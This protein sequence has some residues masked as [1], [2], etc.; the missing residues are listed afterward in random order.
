MLGNGLGAFTPAA[1]S[2]ITVSGGPFST[3]TAD[4][5]N[6]GKLD[7]ATGNFAGDDV[8]ILLGQGDGTFTP[9]ASSPIAVGQF[10]I[11]IASADLNGDGNADL[12]TANYGSNNLSILLGEGNGAFTSA[13]GS[14]VATANEPY[15]VKL[16]DI[17]GDGRIDMVSAN[18]DSQ[19]NV[20]LFLGNGGGKFSRTSTIPLASGGALGSKDVVIVDLDRDGLLDI[21][22]ANT[23]ATTV[24]ILINDAFQRGTGNFAAPGGSPITVGPSPKSLRWVTLTMMDF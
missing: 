12:V 4:F 11:S 24:S 6:D 19:N 16:A 17:N 8:S 13:P 14:P 10:P 20:N 21:A 3:T 18:R 1:S 5:N 15:S 22:S 2:P 7:L 9:H 23:N